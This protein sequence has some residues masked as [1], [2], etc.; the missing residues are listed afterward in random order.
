M[1]PDP[2]AL[3][4]SA[5]LGAMLACAACGALSW[6]FREARPRAGGSGRG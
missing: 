6:L 1:D 4:V 5:A 3:I 2:T